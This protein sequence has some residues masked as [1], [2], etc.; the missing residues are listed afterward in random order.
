MIFLGQELPHLITR[1]EEFTFFLLKLGTQTTALAVESIRCTLCAGVNLKLG[2]TVSH[3]LVLSGKCL[4]LTAHQAIIVGI[5]SCHVTLMV[6]SLVQATNG[7]LLGLNLA[8]VVLHHSIALMLQ[9]LVLSLG[10]NKL[11]LKLLH[12]LVV[13]TSASK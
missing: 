9:S 2:N 11:P 10:L 6:Q 5:G 1:L 8:A 13:W 7:V 12:L 4:V 3:H